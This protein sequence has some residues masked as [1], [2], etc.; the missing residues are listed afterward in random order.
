MAP[1]YSGLPDPKRPYKAYAAAGVT[2]LGLLWAQLD[3]L[4]WSAL[5]WQEWVSVLVPTV[6]AFAATYGIPNP[7]PR[8]P[9]ITHDDERGEGAWVPALVVG[10]LFLLA[11]L[12]ALYLNR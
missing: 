9:E 8:P 1:M 6:L 4:D 10:T 3:G 12:L 2:F 5:T 7:A 11:L